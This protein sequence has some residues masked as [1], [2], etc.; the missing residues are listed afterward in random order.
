MLWWLGISIL[1]EGECCI[2]TAHICLVR[3][4]MSFIIG[5]D[6]TFHGTCRDSM[7]GKHCKIAESKT[8]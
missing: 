8:S 6:V 1:I 4:K 2:L 3:G 5:L 7:P